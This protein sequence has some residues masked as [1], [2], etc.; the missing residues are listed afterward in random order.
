[1]ERDGLRER[2]RVGVR[3]AL[4]QRGGEL[5]AGA[6]TLG[7]ERSARNAVPAAIT[8][9]TGAPPSRRRKPFLKTCASTRVV[10]GCSAA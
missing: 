3:P 1:V 10:S 7:E 8:R 5:R 9:S 2:G 4:R 6:R